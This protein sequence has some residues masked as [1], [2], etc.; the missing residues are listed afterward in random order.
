MIKRIC[1]TVKT[2]EDVLYYK[3]TGEG[4]P[5]V[6][7]P[8]AGGDGDIYLPLADR[9]YQNYKVITY[10]RRANRR[11]TMN[12]PEQFDIAQQ[13]RD[14]VAVLHAC[15]EERAYFFGNS[16]GAVIALEVATLFP[17]VVIS[18]I[19]HEPPLAQ[20]APDSEKWLQFFETCRQRAYRFGGSSMAAVKFLLGIQ[21]PVIKMISSQL[22]VNKYL[23]N[24]PRQPEI[25]SIP[26]K[27]ATDYLI[28][29]ELVAVTSYKP[30][31]KILCENKDKIIVAS[32]TY[33]QE[34]KTWLY[35]AARHLAEEIGCEF[36]VLPGHHASFMDDVENWAKEFKKLL[37]N[38]R[39]NIKC[40]G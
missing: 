21:V 17:E 27:V 1:G 10:D 24:E 23:K 36:V 13:A 14:A 32:G 20:L 3:I 5:I 35:E 40:C 30:N 26:Q 37:K 33:A 15:N 29:Q 8:G 31:I 39:F 16:S 38:K 4:V 28:K 2:E 25:K 18:A 11:S 22:K 12:F 9:I 34:R 7:I 6:M 19:I